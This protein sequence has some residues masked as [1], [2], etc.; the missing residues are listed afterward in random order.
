MLKFSPDDSDVRP[1]LDVVGQPCRTTFS[2]VFSL[3]D[4]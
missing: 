2:K 1:D 3:L 4:I